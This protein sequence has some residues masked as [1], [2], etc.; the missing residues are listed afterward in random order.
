MDITQEQKGVIMYYDYDFSRMLQELEELNGT[1]S[2]TY[3]EIREIREDMENHKNEIKQSI[4]DAS[5]VIS[6]LIVL[7]ATVKVIFR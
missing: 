6:A 7:T 2:N 4:L 1:A 3:T 5:I